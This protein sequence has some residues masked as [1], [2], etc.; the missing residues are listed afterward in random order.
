MTCSSSHNHITTS[1]T[2]S[3]A[4]LPANCRRVCGTASCLD[5]RVCQNQ[6]PVNM[7][8]CFT[9]T[10]VNREVIVPQMA[11]FQ[12]QHT[13]IM[14]ICRTTMPIAAPIV[15]G[16][17]IVPH[18]HHHFQPG[19]VQVCNRAFL[20]QHIWIFVRCHTM[21]PYLLDYSDDIFYKIREA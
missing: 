15:H 14:Q 19:Q 1:R 17:G 18:T 8:P 4:P 16:C 9:H 2:P 21:L 3:L 11:L 6:A 12:I 5:H 13:L 7:L 10:E 20:C